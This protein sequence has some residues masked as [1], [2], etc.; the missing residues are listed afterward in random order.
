MIGPGTPIIFDAQR[1]NRKK[2][3]CYESKAFE[4]ESTA[5]LQIIQSPVIDHISNL[6]SSV[7][8]SSVTLTSCKFAS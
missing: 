2:E 3:L 7:T 6:L 1:I 5:T 4:T 8:P